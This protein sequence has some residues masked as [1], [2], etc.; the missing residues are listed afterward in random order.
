MFVLV[1]LPVAVVNVASPV[2]DVFELPLV[3]DVLA[4][5]LVEVAAVLVLEVVLVAALEVPVGPVV[6]PDGDNDPVV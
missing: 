3:V 2:A 1:V 4:E 6:P 5:L